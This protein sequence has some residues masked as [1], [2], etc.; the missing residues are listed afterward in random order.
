MQ[1]DA[2]SLSDKMQFDAKSLPETPKVNTG[3]PD[4]LWNQELFSFLPDEK[5]KFAF[6]N[7]F[8]KV[9]YE[10][11]EAAEKTLKCKLKWTFTM[12]DGN[13]FYRSVAECL[14]HLEGENRYNHTDLRAFIFLKVT[15]TLQ[16]P[17]GSELSE[18]LQRSR[19]HYDPEKDPDYTSFHDYISQQE[20]K[21]KYAT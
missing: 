7:R 16:N 17:D 4:P 2:K 18:F 14:N 9:S 11:L 15:S 10:I 8:A 19:E 3:L 20:R 13:C 12:A 1:F 6:A 21:G 5:P